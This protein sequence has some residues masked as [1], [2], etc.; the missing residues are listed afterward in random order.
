MKKL[1]LNLEELDV[2]QFQVENAG[3]DGTGTVQGNAVSTQWFSAPCL[4]CPPL[5]ASRGAE[6]VC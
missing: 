2:A 4:Y 5:P 6:T 1:K 3:H